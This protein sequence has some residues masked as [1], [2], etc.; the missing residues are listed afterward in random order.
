MYAFHICILYHRHWCLK[1]GN[2]C[3]MK[4][5]HTYKCKQRNKAEIRHD[6][7]HVNGL[8]FYLS[9]IYMS[10]LLYVGFGGLI[11][12]MLRHC[13][14]EYFVETKK[15]GDNF[16]KATGIEHKHLGT[17]YINIIGSFL[18]G[19]FTSVVNIQDS[20]KMYLFLIPGIVASFTTFSTF[21]LQQSE[22]LQRRHYGEWLIYSAFTI[23]TSL[24]MIFVG[25]VIGDSI[26][27]NFIRKN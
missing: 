24:C 11:G 3:R 27:T 8:S 17:I 19:L 23:F 4:E 14:N 25:F 21:I 6:L 7:F 2:M 9:P 16:T 13:I 15:L 22:Y 18:I 5:F 20:Y 26:H 12:S 1:R 10:D